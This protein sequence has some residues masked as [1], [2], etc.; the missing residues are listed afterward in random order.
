MR[1]AR[2]TQNYIVFFVTK[3]KYN[4]TVEYGKICSDG[5][6]CTYV[7]LHGT[8]DVYERMVYSYQRFIPNVHIITSGSVDGD[9][10]LLQ[11]GIVIQRDAEGFIHESNLMQQFQFNVDLSIALILLRVLL[12]LCFIM[13]R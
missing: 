1:H 13:L 8:L 2:G 11:V 6:E 9:T 7:L 3:K 4:I 5:N 12:L 10:Y